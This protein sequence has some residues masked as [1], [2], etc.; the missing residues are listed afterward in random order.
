MVLLKP[1]IFIAYFIHKIS[2]IIYYL[3]INL[4]TGVHSWSRNFCNFC[5]TV[6]LLKARFSKL[7]RI[8]Q[9]EKSPKRRD[10][11]SARVSN[12]NRLLLSF[13]F[14][15]VAIMPFYWPSNSKHLFLIPILWPEART[16]VS[17]VSFFFQHLQTNKSWNFIYISQKTNPSNNIFNSYNNRH[18]CIKI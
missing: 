18:T 13:L 11:L 17:N 10:H 14:P 5:K 3:S 6:R 15:R 1:T 16:Q 12:R 8:G 7:G 9:F 4:S 2:K